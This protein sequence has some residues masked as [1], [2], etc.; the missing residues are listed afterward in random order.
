MLSHRALPEY[1]AVFNES[2]AERYGSMDE[3][4]VNQLGMHPEMRDHIR[5]TCTIER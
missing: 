2:I 4:M 5:E 1:L 3:F